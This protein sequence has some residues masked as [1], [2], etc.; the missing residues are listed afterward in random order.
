MRIYCLIMLIFFWCNK[1]IVCDL[2]L[3]KSNK[4]IFE[5]G[6]IAHDFFVSMI[7]EMLGKDEIDEY[8]KFIKPLSEKILC[9]YYKLKQRDQYWHINKHN[10]YLIACITIACKYHCDEAIFNEDCLDYI[11]ETFS[12]RKKKYILS[13]INNAE[14]DILHIIN[15]DIF[16]IQND[17]LLKKP[18]SHINDNY[19]Y[20]NKWANIIM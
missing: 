11:E 16:K 13:L 7:S 14:A 10:I 20:V 12:C 8:I 15:W 4:I 18:S 17:L 2:P 9:R 3:H 5:S 19:Y 1:G 6:I